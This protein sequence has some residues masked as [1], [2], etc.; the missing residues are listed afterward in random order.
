MGTQFRCK[1]NIRREAV[2][3][4]TPPTLNGIDYLEVVSHD[5]QTLAVHFIHPLPGQ[6]NGVPAAPV[7]TKD[8]FV[9]EGGARIRGIHVDLEITVAGE[10]TTLHVNVAGDF[11]IYTLR[12]ATSAAHPETPPAAF[13]P[14]LAA[15]DFSFKVE[16]PSDFDCK[17]KTICPPPRRSEP[18]IDYLAKDYSSFR[19]LMLDR[20]S[21]LMPD[22]RERNPADL[23]IALVEL[24]AYAGDH[25]SYFQDAVAT[26]AYLGTARGRISARR[27]ARLLDYSIHDGVNARTWVYI[28]VTAGGMADGKLLAAGC[29]LLARDNGQPSIAF[30]DL[31]REPVVFETM[32]E[33]RLRAAHNEFAF[34]TWSDTECCLPRGATRATLLAKPGATLT[35]GDVLI[36]Q[37]ILS[38]GNGLAADV[39]PT[40]R[41]AVR[42]IS[43]V[44]ATD[45]IDGTAVIEVEWHADDALPFP[46]CLSATVVP[47][48]GVA[49]MAQISI[50]RGNIVLADEGFTSADEP[51]IPLQVPERG[52]YRPQLGRRGL[53]F[54]VPYHHEAEAKNAASVALVQDPR[55]ALPAGSH[56]ENFGQMTLSDGDEQWLP[57]RDLLGSDRF[58][59]EFVVETELDGIARL[60]FGDGILGKAPASKATLRATYRT[61]NGRAGNIGADTLKCMVTPLSGIEQV[62]NPI[63]ARGGADPESMEQIRQFA[64]QAFR[65]QERAVTEADYAEVARRHPEV[66]QAAARFRWT[67]SWQTVFVT[68]DRKGGRD[69]DADFEDEM[70]RFLGRFRLAGYDLEINAPVFVPLDIGVLVCVAPG[71]F[72]SDVKQTLLDIFST[73]DLS[74][75]QRGFFHPDNFSFGQPVY[76]SRIYET[77]MAVNGVASVEVTRFSRFG[78]TPNHELD[79]YMLTPAALEIVR[80]DN[81]PNFPENGK[82][83]FEMHGGL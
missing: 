64:P 63:A 16:C 57:R 40:H 47:P 1:N 23:Q 13:D 74:G 5:Q 18:V 45:H 17:P 43:A 35:P 14:Q 25:L 12:L 80:L 4:L 81:D 50:A 42:L 37:E 71:F 44:P 7:L 69:V 77:A 3:N 68:V 82:I 6:S 27:H 65:T 60:R 52:K 26:E 8:N 55:Q 2:R 33:I 51:M 38:P 24:L 28:Q 78:K 11:S 56:L 72:G 36:F 66:Q 76:L 15:I 41:H 9:I 30:A 29:P 83:E 75:G 34:H 31:A 70:R 73:R 62:R 19:R 54:A 48:G 59:G 22:W 53:T 79:N 49:T 58:A 10:L 32:H 21:L 67:G 39:D 61:G 20:L 46:L